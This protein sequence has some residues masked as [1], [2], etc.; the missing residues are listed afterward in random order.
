LLG[1]EEGARA[2]E[3]REASGR[4]G[5]TCRVRERE[6][7]DRVWWWL[8]GGIVS[9]RGFTAVRLVRHQPRL[10]LLGPVE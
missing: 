10:A 7:T 1:W 4:A 5:V 3:E 6:E 8:M 2:S 9:R